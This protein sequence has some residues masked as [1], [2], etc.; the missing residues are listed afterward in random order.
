MRAQKAVEA[1]KA[2]I[3]TRFVQQHEKFEHTFTSNMAESINNVIHTKAPKRIDFS[4]SYVGLAD[5]AVLEHALGHAVSAHSCDLV[6][7]RGRTS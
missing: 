6:R 1:I 5:T 2:L 3:T 4:A 7:P